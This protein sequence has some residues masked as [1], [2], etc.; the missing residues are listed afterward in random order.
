[1]R[2]GFRPCVQATPLIEDIIVLYGSRPNETSEDA[3]HR[4][5]KV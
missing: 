1:M 2:S 5:E 3:V 4:S